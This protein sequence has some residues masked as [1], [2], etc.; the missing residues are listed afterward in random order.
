M[1]LLDRYLLRSAAQRGLDNNHLSP[2][3]LGSGVTVPNASFLATW[4][5]QYAVVSTVRTLDAIEL[6]GE[7]T[8]IVLVAVVAVVTQ[9]NM[10]LPPVT[11][12]D[13]SSGKEGCVIAN[14]SGSTCMC[15]EWATL[16]ITP[17]PK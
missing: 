15:G 11:K 16:L 4:K 6:G 9:Q 8:A 2:P 14:P 12:M 13:L 1:S 7:F 3:D 17:H 5:T 10:D